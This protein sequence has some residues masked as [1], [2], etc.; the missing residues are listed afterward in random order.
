MRAPLT[1]PQ[2]DI[3]DLTMNRLSRYQLTQQ[4]FQSFWDQW[5]HEYLS[6]LQKRPKWKQQHKNLKEGQIV[7]IKEDNLPPTKWILGR[8]IET[9]KGTDGLVRSARL[10]CKGDP[11]MRK[12]EKG[13]A[14]TIISRPIHKLC[15]LPIEDNMDDDEREI[16]E[17]SLIRGEDV[18]ESTKPNP[19]VN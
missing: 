8:I 18:D 11:P 13:K 16:Y 9:F 3:E 17:Q 12:G 2:P 4:L 19:K 1:L 6:R 14:P 15:L 7:V 5:S 10:I